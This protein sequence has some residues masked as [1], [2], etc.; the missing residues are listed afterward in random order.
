MLQRADDDAT[1]I[2]I[3]VGVATAD[4]IL[5]ANNFFTR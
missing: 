3:E 5:A 1:L 4:E 2:D